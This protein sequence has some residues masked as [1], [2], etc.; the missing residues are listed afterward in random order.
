MSELMDQIATNI[1][2]GKD[3]N[4]KPL[5]SKICFNIFTQYICSVKFDYDEPEFQNIV[6]TYDNILWKI[7]EENILNFIPWMQP[8]YRKHTK[9]INSWSNDIRHFIMNRIIEPNN[10]TEDESNNLDDDFDE[11][12]VNEPDSTDL[13]MLEDFLAGHS[14][15]SNFVIQ[16]FGYIALN[17]D[18]G[19]GIQKEIDRITLNGSREVHHTDDVF[20][21]YTMSTIYES[22]RFSSSPIVPH[23]VIRDMAIAGYGIPKDT[24]IFF[25]GYALNK[26]SE[27][28]SN[29][30][31]AFKSER[32][33][34]HLPSLKAQTSKPIHRLSHMKSSFNS[35]DSFKRNNSQA[36]IWSHNNEKLFMPINS[37]VE[38]RTYNMR[39]RTCLVQYMIRCYSF[40]IVTHI[41]QKYN[42]S[43]SD[44]K[45]IKM[46][47][48]K[49]A[50]PYEGFPITLI[51]RIC[52]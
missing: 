12:G 24:I 16:V 6:R 9:L 42:V 21:P 18:A 4:L 20:M 15:L 11:Y 52:Q 5:I 25:N 41:L 29:E 35:G 19:E 36:G 47:L 50:L 45:L 13:F 51:P 27:Y 1:T 48:D 37:I 2:P 8:F 10:K 14:A 22:L 7:N 28:W 38:Y 23:A 17:P 32:F 46:N 3:Y 44:P 39:K 31:D 40:M 34:M 30:P 43:V 26:S 33:L 49:L